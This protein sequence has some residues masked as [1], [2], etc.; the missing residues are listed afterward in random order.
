MIFPVVF[1]ELV[2]LPVFGSKFIQLNVTE[3]VIVHHSLIPQFPIPVI[4]KLHVC[5]FD[6]VS[7]VIVKTLSHQ[8]YTHILALTNVIR[9]GSVSIIV[10]HVVSSGP[11]F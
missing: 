1:T 4:I 11:L 5:Q 8:L 9:D 6:N 10:I 2:L 7:P 3:F